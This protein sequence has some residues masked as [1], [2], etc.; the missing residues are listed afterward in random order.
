ME[1]LLI[2]IIIGVATA[3]Y[4][5][6]KNNDHNG[7]SKRNSRPFSINRPKFQEVY[8]KIEAN[9]APIPA[10]PV[11]QIP[12]MAQEKR[13]YAE[14]GN[15][16]F[17]SLIYGNT[18]PKEKD[19]AKMEKPEIPLEFPEQKKL[20]EAIIWSEILGEPRSKRPYFSKKSI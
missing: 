7:N 17:N 14:K 8:K 12:L 10:T 5:M 2:A 4:K 20:V 19:G 11:Q 16:N 15:N 3:L 18:G 9:T 6:V 13:Y 1:T